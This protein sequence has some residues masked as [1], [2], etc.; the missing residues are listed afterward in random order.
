MS[1]NSVLA[2][3]TRIIGYLRQNQCIELL[4]SEIPP[5]TKLAETVRDVIYGSPGADFENFSFAAPPAIIGFMIF[6]Y[7]L[8]YMR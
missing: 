3:K 6:S 7:C 4:W 1:L 2:S 8:V 5:I